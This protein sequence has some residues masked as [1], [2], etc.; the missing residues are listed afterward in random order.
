MWGRWVL[1]IAIAVLGAS[2]AASASEGAGS[3]GYRHLATDCVAT[4]TA[5]GQQVSARTQWQMWNGHRG[6]DGLDGYRW[7]ARLI[8]AR[9]GFNFH[10]V[11]EAVEL[12]DVE[13]DASGNY[14]ATVTTPPM[15]SN[16]DWDL[17]VKLT[18]DRAGRSDW[19]V[20]RVLEFDEGNCSVW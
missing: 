16:L 14:H 20:E 19:N 4:Q 11:W 15:S 10:R 9:P 2:V 18:W 17:Q 1:C 5:F 12:D 3:Y 6:A 7:Q 8:P 13:E